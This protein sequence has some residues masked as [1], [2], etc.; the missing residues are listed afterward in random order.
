MPWQDVVGGKSEGVSLGDDPYSNYY[1]NGYL[2]PGITKP[3]RSQ[4]PEV[5]APTGA[6]GHSVENSFQDIRDGWEG[7][8]EDWAIKVLDAVCDPYF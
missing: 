3:S 5:I 7:S 6:L 1:D 8:P 2:I 4:L